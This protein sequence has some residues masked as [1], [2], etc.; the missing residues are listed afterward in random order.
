M[1]I[2]SHKSKR[3][4]EKLLT[5][6]MQ[7]SGLEE[8]SRD[9]NDTTRRTKNLPSIQILPVI[10]V[11]YETPMADKIDQNVFELT[12]TSKSPHYYEI[13]KSFSADI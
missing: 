7:G 1:G 6:S 11:M 8:N 10:S 4:L 5:A 9:E 2:V 13:S 3:T 12:E